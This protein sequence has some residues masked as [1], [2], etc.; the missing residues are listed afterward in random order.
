MLEGHTQYSKGRGILS[1]VTAATIAASAWL[2]PPCAL[3]SEVVAA[4]TSEAES[5]YRTGIGLAHRGLFDLAATELRA[6]LEA[7]LDGPFQL[8]AKYTL[9][10]CAVE[11]GRDSEAATLLDEVLKVDTFEYVADA[12]MLRASIATR[13]KE[14]GKAITVLQR[15]IEKHPK[16]SRASEANLL[17]GQCELAQESLPRASAAF[18]R[19]TRE[20]EDRSLIDQARLGLAEIARAQRQPERAIEH[21]SKL[22]GGETD[23]SMRAHAAMIQAWGLQALGR[24][25]EVRPLLE[26][27][28]ASKANAAIAADATLALAML[29]RRDG[30]SQRALDLL[31]DLVSA[32]APAGI[33]HAA[34]LE[35]SLAAIELGRFEDAAAWLDALPADAEESV[36]ARALLW[37]A[38]VDARTGHHAEAALKYE[39]WL[40]DHAKSSDREEVEYELAMAMVDAGRT[41]DALRVLAGVARG[42]E[43]SGTKK[44]SE[45]AQRAL[46]AKATLELRE[47]KLREADQSAAQAVGHLQQ[48]ML[49]A[50]ARWIRVECAYGEQRWADVVK[51]SE[52]HATHHP[53]H[54]RWA[55]VM[56]LRGL[57]LVQQE[58][59]NDA[60]PVLAMAI[61][62]ERSSSLEPE[63]AKAAL[64]ALGDASLREKDWPAAERWFN[65]ALELAPVVHDASLFYRLGVALARQEQRER[66]L[67]LLNQAA[68]LLDGQGRERN[69]DVATA[70]EA[71]R[72]DVLLA[73]GR[74]DEADAAA[75]RIS[76]SAQGGNDAGRVARQRALIASRQ[77]R[78]LDAAEHLRL[79][80]EAEG[81]TSEGFASRLE[82]AALLSSAGRP[83]EAIEAYQAVLDRPEAGKLLSQ[84]QRD[85]ARA[86][87]ALEHAKVDRDDARMLVLL[88]QAA[89][90]QLK[91]ET[92]ARLEYESALRHRRLGHVQEAAT[93]LGK[94]W[95]ASS[96]GSLSAERTGSADVL[97][98][99]RLAA[100]VE[101]A[102][103]RLDS[104]QAAG[105][106]Q[107]LDEAAGVLA[108]SPPPVQ[109]AVKG[110]MMYARGATLH[111]LERWEEADVALEN[112]LPLIEDASARASISLMRGDALSSRGNVER[113]INEYELAMKSADA[114][115]RELARARLA[116]ALLTAQRW[117]EAEQA[118]RDVLSSKTDVASSAQARFGLG[119]ALEARGLHEQAIAAYKSV[120][121]ASPQTT[122]APRANF[123]IGECLF[124]LGRHEQAVAEFLKV[125]VLYAQNE[126]KPAA[127]FEAGRCLEALGRNADATKQYSQLVERFGESAWA[128][129][130]RDRVSALRPASLPGQPNPR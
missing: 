62:D 71:E 20:S 110:P 60:V 59:G 56:V 42:F 2:V 126:W 39:R 119:S 114:A 76:R 37:R 98:I 47:G 66:A 32:S 112:A 61:N 24:S 118:F 111:R 46:V 35:R 102:W 28:I 70:I 31:A 17:L 21:A 89:K 78:S 12:A 44:P 38:R 50:E 33:R 26:E 107:L 15:F 3:A 13:A 99:T 52:E 45:I 85:E 125:D 117:D 27:A 129:K 82:R 96:E 67:D 11:V 25:A 93:L 88:E 81:W 9:A 58:R 22:R 75:T 63:L 18:E 124:A 113:A 104:N 128:T 64:T 16:S 54:A 55:R 109:S 40:H 121:E 36:K 87:L 19:V 97:V 105:A 53:D 10:V 84:S 77:G 30:R 7:G 69:T 8:S 6:S 91:P 57:A 120:L 127:L 4:P 94:L 23:A 90:A 80:A 100:C 115:Q 123:Q 122:L 68:A 92:R 130:A 51:R 29:E 106:L 95:T 108:G 5:R 48:E 65:R 72:S 74:L 14:W 79:A 49:L 43:G 83:T 41:A 86:A 101:L 116:Q 1:L 103:L 34:I 73:L